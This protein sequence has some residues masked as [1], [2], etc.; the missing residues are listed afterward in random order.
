MDEKKKT[1]TFSRCHVNKGQCWICGKKEGVLYHGVKLEK[2]TVLVPICN[3]CIHLLQGKTLEG[4]FFT[5]NE[6]KI[7]NILMDTPE[8]VKRNELEKESMMPKSSLA[9]V[10]FSLEKR[11][12]V[13]VDKSSAVHFVELSEW[14]KSL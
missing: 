10:L 6:L 14:F 12:I 5:P 4:V 8:G 3:I 7:V 1:I 9:S 11:N 13:V 2:E